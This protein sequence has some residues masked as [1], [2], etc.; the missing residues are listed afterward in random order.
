M[1]HPSM[2]TTVPIVSVNMGLVQPNQPHHLVIAIMVAV[3]QHK[4]NGLAFYAI[5]ATR[6]TRNAKVIANQSF[7]VTDVSE[8]VMRILHTITT[9]AFVIQCVHRV[10]PVA[11]VMGTELAMTGSVIVTPIGSTMAANSV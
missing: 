11:P 8:Y 1:E 5:C 7:L 4:A 9:T 3:V 10:G 2:E 6:W